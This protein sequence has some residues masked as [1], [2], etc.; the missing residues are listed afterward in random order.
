MRRVIYVVL[1]VI[2]CCLYYT[3]TSS[4]LALKKYPY[5]SWIPLCE[6]WLTRPVNGPWLSATS[7]TVTGPVGECLQVDTED[8][9]VLDCLAP[10]RSLYDSGAGF[11]CRI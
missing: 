6:H 9:S 5:S 10:L 8:T 2:W 7:T 11:W 4:D 3:R 1:S